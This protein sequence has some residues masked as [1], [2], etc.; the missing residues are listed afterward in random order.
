MSKKGKK[1]SGFVVFS[2]LILAMALLFASCDS[3]AG[4]SGDTGFSSQDSGDGNSQGGN[5][6]DGNSQGGNQ[7]GNS[8]GGN[9]G[10][11]SQ[12]GNGGGG[13]GGGSGGGGGGTTTTYTVTFYSN[14]GDPVSTQTVNSGGKASD[15]GNPG[16]V[17]Y[18]FGGWY[19]DD[20]SF[21]NFYNFALPVSG[22]IDLYAKWGWPRTT[23]DG[24]GTALFQAVTVDQ[25]GNVYAVGYQETSGLLDYG[26]GGILGSLYNKPVLV[27]YNALGTTQWT[28]TITTD[29]NAAVFNAVAVDQSGNVYIAGN[30]YGT[31][32]YNYGSG[33]IAGP[34]A[35][36]N[37]VLIK[38]NAA[39]T[40]LWAKTIIAGTDDAGIF[41]I[42]CD[43]DGNVYAAAC[44][45]GNG[46]YNYGNGNIAGSS[47]FFNPV[48]VKYNAAGT[49]LWARTITAGTRDAYFYSVTLD[50]AGNVYVAGAQN[51][52]GNFDYGSG[53]ISGP[54]GADNPVLVKYDAA[55][56]TLWA[57]SIMA[58]TQNAYFN[59]V[60]IDPLGNVYAAGCQWGTGNFDYGSGN[61]AGTATS[62]NSVLV[63][64][65]AAGNALWARVITEGT[66]CAVFQ[67]LAAD[68]FGNIYAAGYQKGSGNYNYGN[69]NIAG[70]STNFN[71][72]LVKYNSVGTTLWARTIRN[73]AIAR[74]QAVKVDISNVY[75]AGYQYGS[76]SYDYGSGNIAGST[77]QNPVVVKYDSAGNAVN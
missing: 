36:N 54:L 27:K 51:G 66:D 38:Y 61:I 39:G 22:N 75:A 53:N 59:A 18:G 65:D 77:V 58:S 33:N 28:R 68:Q 16:R 71:P 13:S 4:D 57:T 3:P 14:G 1:L 35:A 37:P 23:T 5:N 21:S 29:A 64:Y 48:L 55:G 19:S 20:G 31:G 74:F 40:A 70:A 25:T 6:Q 47:T 73:G 63:K 62:E 12:G 76:G 15:P 43:Q 72:V 50:Q 34:L 44:Q 49:A 2:I 26:S 9:Q 60:T 41:A 7:G 46:D 10:G 52:T 32:N 30:Q 42:S 67:G 17:G 8:Q 45:Y 24:G 69:G 11:N 56:N